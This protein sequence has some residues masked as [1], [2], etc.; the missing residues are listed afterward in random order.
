MERAE[1]AE[2]QVIHAAAAERTCA[3][4][5]LAADSLQRAKDNLQLELSRLSLQ[6]R[7]PQRPS[8][9]ALA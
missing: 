9:P 5:R 6:R 2:I 1:R 7:A 8:A 3:T 4:L